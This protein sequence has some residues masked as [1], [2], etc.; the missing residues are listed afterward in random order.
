MRKLDEADRRAMSRRVMGVVENGLPPLKWM[1]APWFVRTQP[2][3]HESKA[4]EKVWIAGLCLGDLRLYNGK[5][6][7]ALKA[8]IMA[9]DEGKFTP[10]TIVTCNTSGNYGAQVGLIAPMFPFKEFRPIIDTRSVP[11]GKIDQLEANGIREIIPVP[12]GKI[13][14]DFAY[15]VAQWP[16][17]Y[18]MDQYTLEASVLGHEWTMNQIIRDLPRLRLKMWQEK[19]KWVGEKLSGGAAVIGTGSTVAAM[20]RFL[21]PAFPSMKVWGI[22]SKDKENK[23]PGSR[24]PK[25]LD[26]LNSIGGGF[27]YKNAIDGGLITSVTLDETYS[28]NGELVMPYGID[29]GPTGALALAGTWY[30]VGEHWM[31]H[32]GSFKGLENDAGIVLICLVTI[33]QRAFYLDDPKYRKYF[34]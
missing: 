33:D 17:H 16:D 23:V 29:V 13:G 28:V 19:H 30:R 15:E 8:C 11:K 14:T 21:R 7:A 22:A 31:N 27:D 32:G 34:Q 20:H 9:Q 2:W 10:E 25:T 3:Y 24:F 6:P 26:E 4:A 5:L 12:E 18:L 1:P